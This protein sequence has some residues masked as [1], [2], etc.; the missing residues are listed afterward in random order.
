[1]GNPAFAYKRREPEKTLLYETVREHLA[2]FITRSFTCR[3]LWFDIRTTTL[4]ASST[5]DGLSRARRTSLSTA[6]KLRSWRCRGTFSAHRSEMPRR[7]SV[8]LTSSG[9]RLFLFVEPSTTGLIT[10]ATSTAS[11]GLKR[12]TKAQA[13][14]NRWSLHAMMSRARGFLSPGNYLYLPG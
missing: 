7:T 12:E 9:F 2:T 13:Q 3:R 14:G 8:P 11:V 10:R 5:G 4:Y 1:M 6:A